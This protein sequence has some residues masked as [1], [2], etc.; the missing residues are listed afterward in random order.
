MGLEQVAIQGDDGVQ[1]ALR[2]WRCGGR[3]D[4]TGKTRPRAVLQ[5]S[6]GMAEHVGRYDALARH[7]NR[8]GIAV[9]GHDHRGHG[10]N[11]G[12]CPGH[13]ADVDGWDRVVGD[14]AAVH[15]YIQ[16]EYPGLPV[17]LL[18]HSMGSFISLAY[19]QRHRPNYRGVLLSGSDYTAPLKFRLALPVARAEKR[20]FG[21]RGRSPVM[22]FLSFGS[23]N[24]PFKPHRTP[25]D[26]LSR[27]AA[28]VDAYIQ[29]RDCGFDCTNQLWIDLLGGLCEIFGRKGLCRL[30]NLP[31]YLFAGEMDP[32]G[33]H[34]HGVRM[35]ARQLDEAGVNDVTLKLYPEGRHEMLNE[36][37][38]D[39][40]IRDLLDWLRARL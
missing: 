28:Q 16:A 38:R 33:Q 3:T 27:D 18:G 22:T 15:R 12:H 34:G 11:K 31:Y 2:H 25:Y 20:V 29:D 4:R 32:V 23:F 7:L 40:V 30:Q 24:K 39:E 8:E 19:L 26:W 1:I 37:N 17:F 9:V 13:Y 10:M 14:L 6:H 5:L 35:L 21:A 36:S